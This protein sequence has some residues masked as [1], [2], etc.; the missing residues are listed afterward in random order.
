MAKKSSEDDYIKSMVSTGVGNLV[1]IGLIGATANAAAGL[2]AG[3]AKTIAGTAVGLQSTALL[4]PNI[5][6]VKQSLGSSEKK[7]K[8]MKW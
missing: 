3:T 2:P 6:L 7:S 4:G 8:K 1:G 5:K